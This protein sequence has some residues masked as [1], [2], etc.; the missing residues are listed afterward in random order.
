MDKRGSWSITLTD[1]TE[2][3][4]GRNDPEQRLERFAPLLPRLA[5]QHPGQRLVRADLRY[6]NGFSLS[7]AA[8]PKASA[9]PAPVQDAPLPQPA[10][11]APAGRNDT[12]GTT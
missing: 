11:D 6:T 5:A 1:G 10:P 12:Q 8:L 4:L 3:V 2:V 7:W 9:L